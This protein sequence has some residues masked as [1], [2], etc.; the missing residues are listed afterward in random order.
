MKIDKVRIQNFQCIRDS[1]DVLLDEHITVLVGENES[2]KSAI[3]KALSYFN[4]G[5]SFRDVDVSTLS[6]DIRQQL[7]TG[8]LERESVEMV[9]VWVT[10]S[11]KE[12][13][14]IGVPDQ[15]GNAPTFKIVKSLANRYKVFSE[16]GQPLLDVQANA[17]KTQVLAKLEDLQKEVSKVYCGQVKRKEPLDSFVFLQR[18]EGEELK[19]NL[20][21]FPDSAGNI[22]ERIEAGDSLQVTKIARDPFGRNRRALNA[23]FAFDLDKPLANFAQAVQ[24]DSTDSSE[25]LLHFKEVIKELPNNH[26]VRDYLTADVIGYWEEICAPSKAKYN[27][28]VLENNILQ[29]LPRFV[30]LPTVPEV[31]DSISCSE[32]DSTRV[33]ESDALLGTLLK[34]AG[35]RPEAVAAKEPAERMQ[36]LREKSKIITQRLREYW[37]KKD[38]TIEFDFLNQDRDIGM[39]VDSDGS[40]DPPSRRSKGF[41]SYASLFAMLSQLSGSQN[42]V[43]LLDDLAVHLHPVAQRNILPLLEAQQ[44][45]IILATHLPFLIDPEHL[46]RVRVVKRVSAGSMVEHD[47]SKAQQA[48]LPVWGSLVGSFAGRVWLLV[49][50]KKDREYYN[51]LNRACKKESRQYLSDDVVIVPGGGD[52]LAYLAQAL[53]TRGV[54]FIAVLDGDRPGQDAKKRLVNLCGVEPERVITL[55]EIGLSPTNPEVE[56]LFSPEFKTTRNVRGRGLTQAIADVEKGEAKFD[57]ET[58]SSFEQVFSL[59]NKAIARFYPR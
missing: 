29:S 2:G 39:A 35:L 54:F 20:I 1:Q 47:W 19:D 27:P 57:D 34:L 55:G 9:A 13:S 6:G 40:F 53:H 36:I 25:A 21:L 46:E 37:F 58:L 32:V 5:E 56:D 7:E 18:T 15:F 10:L 17:A 43:L 52:Q 11:D 59:V 45:Q 41:I 30:Y 26:P 3:L 28:L 38:I 51:A 24:S 42:I 33:R 14:T 22:W 48:L 4:Q 50:G 8:E 44:Y 31:S 49:E 23:G 12:R 16:A